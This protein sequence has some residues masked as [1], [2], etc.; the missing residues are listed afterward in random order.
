MYR[1][2]V[3]LL[4][5]LL[6]LL[7]A[8]VASAD[9]YPVK[10]IRLIVPGVAGSPP[11]VRARWLADKLY[12]ALGQRVVVDNKPGA[13][14]TLGAAAV[15]H[16]AADGYTLLAVTQGT[17][18]FSP[19]LY[20]EPGFNALTDFAP[21]TRISVGSLLLAVYP[22]AR[23]DTVAQLIRL[24]KDKPGT[25]TFGSAGIGSPPHMAG[26]LFRR[27]AGIEVTYV[28]YK[29]G[30]EAHLDVVAGR[31]TYTMEGIGIL[32]PYVKA[33]KLKALAVTGPQRVATLPDVPTIAESGL[34]NY[35][36]EVWTGI[37]APAG[38]PKEIV[39]RLNTELVKILRTSEAQE[40]F[41]GQGV[42][43]IG[44]SPEEFATLIRADYAKWGTVIKASGMKPE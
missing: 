24:A 19:H 37:C 34:A 43:P 18:A 12:P 38:T 44:D 6:G 13:G 27:Q 41:A 25:L 1:S 15:A 2:T 14:G 42:R 11:D 28:P 20:N 35:D 23:V 8:G 5:M 3:S 4:S 40:W 7:S 33:G 21:I 9:S 26:E 17:L 22:G 31:I 32:L 10:P 36:Y 29:G 16:S 39:A 30:N